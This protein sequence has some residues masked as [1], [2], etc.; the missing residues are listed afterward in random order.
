[1]KPSTLYDEYAAALFKYVRNIKWRVFYGDS[2]LD[3]QPLHPPT[4]PVDPTSLPNSSSDI[5]PALSAYLMKCED[6]LKSALSARPHIQ[7]SSLDQLILDTLNSLSARPDL[8]YKPAD[9]NL[10]TTVMLVDQ[11]NKLCTDI[12]S[13][14]STY[15]VCLDYVPANLYTTLRAVLQ[16]HGQLYAGSTGPKRFEYSRL[17]RSLLQLSR[18]K[19]RRVP[20][21]YCLPKMHKPGAIKGRPIVSSINSV[22][23][24]TSVYL[25]NY[26]VQFR[27]YIPNICTNSSDVV[28]DLES[29]RTDDPNLVI[30]CADVASLY[31][32]IPIPYGLQAVRSFLL[33]FRTRDWQERPTPG[34]VT[35]GQ[36]DLIIDLLEWVL[37]NNYMQFMGVIYHQLT[38][39]AMGTPVAV[40]FADIVLAYLERSCV[41]RCKPTYYSRYLDDLFIILHKDYK[42]EIVQR[43][44]AQCSS[45]QLDAVTNGNS[46]VYLDLMISISPDLDRP[47]TQVFQKSI[48]RFQYITPSSAHSPSVAKNLVVTELQRYRVRCSDDTTFTAVCTQFYDRL[49]DRGYAKEY[50]DILFRFPPDRSALLSKLRDQRIRRQEKQHARLHE[51]PSAAPSPPPLVYVPCIYNRA[52]RLPWQEILQLPD[53]VTNHVDMQTTYGEKDSMRIIVGSKNPKNAA[54]Y[55][56][57]LRHL[58]PTSATE[59]GVA[60]PSART[61]PMLSH[62]GPLAPSA[63]LQRTPGSSAPE[64]GRRASAP[65]LLRQ[66]QLSD[67]FG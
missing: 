40:M 15:E 33:S 50:L 58:L 10:G 12:L 18:D 65:N 32:S 67:Y 38:G 23:Y 26:L 60:A 17:A 47:V 59:L 8:V 35:N 21:F 6:R 62:P 55:L 66:T 45:I 52:L 61:G 2:S 20:A 24:H 25:H 11:Y 19:S 46:G 16:R 64:R 42:D 31:P 41:A 56:S 3:E 5:Q 34:D 28:L 29:V 30:V 39:T 22:T 53:D 1:M 13:D 48:N 7:L 27:P 63:T 14:T 54:Y 43:F 57:R 4:R 37:K 36:I 9:K 49:V 51:L 44:N